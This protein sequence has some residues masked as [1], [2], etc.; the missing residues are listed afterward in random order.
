MTDQPEQI[1]EEGRPESS[2]DRVAREARATCV[3]AGFPTTKTPL[4]DAW[5]TKHTGRDA[6]HVTITYPNDLRV[7]VEYW[8]SGVDMATLHIGS[9][10][11]RDRRD[12]L[13]HMLMAALEW[14]DMHELDVPS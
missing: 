14:L 2:A 13:R 6:P 4:I 8:G 10:S 11:I 7:S 5:H 1:L 9:I 3:E 12:D